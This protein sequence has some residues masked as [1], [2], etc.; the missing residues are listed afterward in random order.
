MPTP[1]ALRAAV[2]GPAA[3][4]IG[5]NGQ[6]QLA[7]PAGGQ[8]DELTASEA[9][10]FASAWARERAPMNRSWLE[11]THGAP[12]N[13][14]ALKNCGRPLYARS[15]L[16]APPQSIPGPYRRIHGPWWLVTFCDEGGLPSVSIAVSAWVTEV[17]IE[18]GKLRFPR[19]SG[20]E[21]VAVG[22]P[23]G[24]V[25]EYPMPPEMAVEMVA[26]QAG[27]RIARVPE[28]VTPLPS[29]G[30][31]MLARWRLTLEGPATVRTESGMRAANEVFVSPTYVGGRD[32]ATSVAAPAQSAAIDLNWTPLP[33]VGEARAAYA[34]RA[35]KQTT[36]LLRRVDTPARVERI[37]AWGN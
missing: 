10:N 5:P 13:F 32:I 27:K 8:E 9:V 24:H 1:S 30:P 17:T 12:I 2:T 18:A 28:L 33:R 26:Q 3:D 14:K 6:I 34:A 37:S 35:V 23:V 31:P 20:T 22:V 11:R 19:I 29:D 21:F 15:A 4:A 16:S 36:K 7:P 25:G